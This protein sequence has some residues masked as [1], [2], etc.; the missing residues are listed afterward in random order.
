MA[1]PIGPGDWVECVDI[2]PRGPDPVRLAAL[3]QLSLGAIYRCRAVQ[4]TGYGVFLDGV[5][6]AYEAEGFG[7][8]VERF[9]PI[10]R[11]KAHAFDHLLAP[12][13]ENTPEIA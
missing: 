13:P 11:P 1:A 12:T 8:R 4:T 3:H 2:A 7:W 10:Y 9:R 5:V 6:A